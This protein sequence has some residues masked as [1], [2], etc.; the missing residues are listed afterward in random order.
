MRKDKIFY[1]DSQST[2][3]KDKEVCNYDYLID[4]PN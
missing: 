2:L 4:Y 1:R 3:Q